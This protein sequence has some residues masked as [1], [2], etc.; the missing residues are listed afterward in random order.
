MNIYSTKQFE[1]ATLEQ[2]EKINKGFVK[3]AYK[4]KEVAQNEFVNNGIY[5]KLS[6]LKGGIML[7]K[8]ENNQ[9][10]LHA[11]GYD[12]KEEQTYKTRFFVGGTTDRTTYIKQKRKGSE[13]KIYK[14]SYTKKDGSVSHYYKS[15]TYKYNKRIGKGHSTG[16]IEAIDTITKILPQGQTI[17]DNYIKQELNNG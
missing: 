4:I 13:R 7:G 15:V 2:L 12:D 16:K 11:L 1:Q 6:P 3:A 8:F 17:L 10:T 5:T 14:S 9:V